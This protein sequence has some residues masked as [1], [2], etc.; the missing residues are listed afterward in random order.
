[1]CHLKTTTVPV[2]VIAPCMTQ[3]GTDKHIDKMHDRP[4][5]YEVQKNSPVDLRILAVTQNSSE[6][7]STKGSV[8]KLTRVK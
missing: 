3:K 5:P 8:K 7:T 2:I 6:K 1:M 4:S